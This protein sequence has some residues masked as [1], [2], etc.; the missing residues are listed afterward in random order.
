MVSLA[1]QLIKKFCV[2]CWP[3]NKNGLILSIIKR[4]DLVDSF[5][6]E[7][8]DVRKIFQ[9][10]LEGTPLL[11]TIPVKRLYNVKIITIGT[12]QWCCEHYSEF[13]SSN[14]IAIFRNLDKNLKKIK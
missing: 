6:L 10:T 5:G 12:Y 3:S 13:A 9:Y 7:Q 1:D 14:N 2:V 4:S 11:N 8:G